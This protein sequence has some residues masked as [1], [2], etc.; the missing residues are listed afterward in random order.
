[1]L[2]LLFGAVIVGAATSGP[3]NPTTAIDNTSVGSV[4]WSNPGR[5]T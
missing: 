5:V 1:V 2:L 3:N 4:I